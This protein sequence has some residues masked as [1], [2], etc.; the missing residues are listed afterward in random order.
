MIVLFLAEIPQKMFKKL[1]PG[2]GFGHQRKRRCQR[3]SFSAATLP[4]FLL[5]QFGRRDSVQTTRRRIPVCPVITTEEKSSE[6]PNNPNARDLSKGML[7]VPGKGFE[8]NLLVNRF[9]N[10]ENTWL[11]MS[12]VETHTALDSYKSF[13]EIWVQ[14]LAIPL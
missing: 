10:K 2:K 6:N 14:I 13:F 9:E 7:M 1:A 3:S 12:P 4:F 11:G 5:K 8:P